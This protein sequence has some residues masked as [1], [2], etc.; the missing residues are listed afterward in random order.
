MLEERRGTH[1]AFDVA[2]LEVQPVHLPREDDFRVADG[3]PSMRTRLVE[4]TFGLLEAAGA[5]RPAAANEARHE[6]VDG[7]TK[8][9]GDA[10]VLGESTVG[11][12]RVAED[13][14]GAEQA[15]VAVEGDARIV[16]ASGEIERLPPELQATLN[17][18]RP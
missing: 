17:V 6:A 16:E 13:Q 8:L 2:A 9:L 3:A 10:C 18:I 14:V 12:S 1:H 15:L 7:L 4:Q 11:S 5:D